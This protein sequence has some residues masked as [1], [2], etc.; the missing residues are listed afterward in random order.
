MDSSSGYHECQPHVVLLLFSVFQS[1]SLFVCAA[2][3]GH[4][5]LSHLPNHYH[6]CLPSSN[7]PAEDIRPAEPSRRFQIPQ[8]SAKN[9]FCDSCITLISSG[10]ASHSSRT[11]N[12]AVT[13]PV[14]W[15][16]PPPALHGSRSP[17]PQNSSCPF[18]S[19]VLQCWFSLN[20]FFTNTCLEFVFAFCC[21]L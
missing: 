12:Y 15:F 17:S 13:S 21:S 10:F 19:W 2:E 7:Q 1:V 14:F 9:L 8:L 18:S 20:S 5:F 16:L 6:T 4:K 11:S 3:R